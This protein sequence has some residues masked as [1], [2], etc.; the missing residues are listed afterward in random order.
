V[1]TISPTRFIRHVAL[2]TLAAC[3]PFAARGQD[4]AGPVNAVTTRADFPGGNIQVVAQ[5]EDVV[6]IAPDLRGDRPWFYWCFEAR[7]ARPGRVKFVFP[8]KVA[9]FT[10]GAIGFQGPAIS[11]DQGASW[12]W[13]GTERVEGSSFSYEFLE[14]NQCVRFAVTIPYL[15]KDLAAF[16]DHHADNPH[17]TKS[18]L[19]TSRKGRE[20]ELLQIG[21]VRPQVHAV[22]VTARHHA[23]ETIASYVLEGFLQEALSES[24]AGVD[25]RKRF[26]LFAVPF[27]DKDGVEEGD[28]GKNRLPHDHNRD[29][30]SE[31]IYPEIQAIKEL[32]RKHDF[33]FALDFHCPTRHGRSSGDVFCRRQATSEAQFP[34]CLGVCGMDP[35]EA[36]GHGSRWTSCVAAARR[37]SAADEFALFRVQEECDHGSD[38]GN[39]VCTTGQGDGSRQLPRLRA[40]DSGGLGQDRVSGY[41]RVRHPASPA[42]AATI[43]TELH[44]LL[45]EMRHV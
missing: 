25:F 35:E 21:S 39:T 12:R 16:L 7:A 8:D 19:A 45:R 5:E 18:V 14:H 10:D 1:A 30:G 31:S 36:A 15:Q 4:A 37:A 40:E 17:L 26:A 22:L 38:A 13:M 44:W 3:L 28:Q 6:H 9:G 41:R 2:G 32:D 23:A 11:M 29:Y 24:E 43:E 33:R 42:G 34:K 27:V 20:V